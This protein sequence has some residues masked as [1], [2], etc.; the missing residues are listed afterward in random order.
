MLS[1][2]VFVVL[3]IWVISL[4]DKVNKLERKIKNN[5]C[6]KTIEQVPK[7]EEEYSSHLEETNN[8]QHSI[9]ENN[10]FWNWLKENWIMKLGALLLLMGFGWL[11]TYAFMNNWVGPAG[12]I[13][14][15]ITAGVVFLIIGTMV[16]RKRQNQGEVF[17][18][19]GSGI[20]LI[21][22]YAARV[23]YDF[24]DPFSS[25]GI[26]FLS[27]V[28]VAF[29]G[30][31]YKSKYLPTISLI[32]AG[33]APLLT[34]SS[35]T[36]Y[37]LLFTYLLIIILG[38]NWVVAIN[39]Q[40]GLILSSLILVIFYSI[41]CL[42][43]HYE[44]LLSFAYIFTIIFF[45]SNIISILKLENDKHGINMLTAG[46]NTL[47]LLGSI[48]VLGK[49]EFKVLILSSW[50]IVFAIA[51]FIVFQKTGKKEPFYIYG[52]SSTALL[53]AATALQLKG[54]SLMI[55][56]IV[57]SV[58]IC[59]STYLIT[60]N[61]NIAKRFSCLLVGPIFLSFGIFFSYLL[62]SNPFSKHLF[63]LLFL[64]LVILFVG[65]FFWK[66]SQKIDFK[67]S[68]VGATWINVGAIFGYA[69]IW[70]FFHKLFTGG[71]IATTIVLIIYTLIA[72]IVYVYGIRNGRKGFRIHGQ[73]LV[74]LVV[75]R[76]LLVDISHMEI[77]G[78]IITFFLIGVLLIGTAFLEKNKS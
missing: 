35:A 46:I 31:K 2:I 25:L 13:L 4:N 60:N 58:I 40:R 45:I 37:I 32:F 5:L 59:L 3:L 73:I 65:L 72:L 26:M 20:V 10:T 69:L 51:A 38:V 55:A 21:T 77:T 36:D 64:I 23:F 6:T 7:A 42:F 18:A 8:A 74:G 1:F 53:A 54:E 75:L 62:Q 63:S 39:G 9:V 27:I 48:L 68:L 70:V 30:V 22:T 43:N 33:L 52:L 47:Y 34:G 78:K 41:P 12:R 67:K 28:F 29:V 15:G 24:F 57:E 49:E 56:Y 66:I 50:M 16:I 61:L 14:L 11:A 44:P 76:L 71:D 19:L 17:L